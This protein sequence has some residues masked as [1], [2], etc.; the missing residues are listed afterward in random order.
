VIK[1]EPCESKFKI[2]L[3]HQVSVEGYVRDIMLHYS[4]TAKKWQWKKRQNN[5]TTQIS[6]ICKEE[7]KRKQREENKMR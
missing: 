6:K 5:P 4:T 2:S 7:R 3:N 1:F